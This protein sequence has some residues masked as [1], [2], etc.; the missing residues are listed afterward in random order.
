MLCGT[1]ASHRCPMQMRKRWRIAFSL[2]IYLPLSHK[3]T[4]PTLVRRNAEFR[5]LFFQVSLQRVCVCVN[6][7]GISCRS[8]RHTRRE[9]ATAAQTIAISPGSKIIGLRSGREG[10]MERALC[11]FFFS[12]FLSFCFVF[13]SSCPLARSLTLFSFPSCLRNDFAL[14][15][16]YTYSTYTH[17]YACTRCGRPE[18]TGCGTLLDIFL[19]YMSLVFFPP[20]C[21]YVPP[22]LS[23]FL[24]H[25]LFLCV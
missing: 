7:R 4:N 25:F 9:P 5:K 12:H 21:V 2:S 3:K 15:D 18:P 20:V 10:R 13:Y 8:V 6:A 23:L 22:S 16:V 11:C 1:G 19:F 14:S 17:M 24:F